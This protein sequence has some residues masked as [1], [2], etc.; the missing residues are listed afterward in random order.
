MTSTF[1]PLDPQTVA[2][3]RE[4]VAP[5]SVIE[6]RD[7]REPFGRD[8]TAEA[9]AMPE[10][11]VEATSAGQISALL[12]LANEFRFPVTPRGL[13]TGL[14]GGAVPI[15]GG[16][17]LSLAKM[18][19]ILTIDRDNFLA[20]VEPGV[21]NKD[22]KDAAR[23]AGLY[24]PPDPASYDTC[25][26]GGNAATNAGGPSCVK[27]GVTREYVLGLEAVLPTGEPIRTGVRTRKGVV[28]YDLTRLLVGSE[29]TLGV[30]TQ[31]VLK[32]IPHPPAITTLVALCPS[33]SGAMEAIRT[34]LGAGYIPCVVEFLDRHC[35]DLVGDLLPF[36]GVQDTGAFLLI[37]TD[38]TPEI[39]AR[40]IEAIGEICLGSGADQ[41]LLAPDAQR[42]ERMWDVRKA[43][44]LRIEERYPVDVHEDIVVPI[45]CI[46]DFV[47][48]LPPLED[49]YGMQ[50]FTFG[51]AGDGNLHL[52]I[53]ADAREARERID[54]GIEEI[55]K[56]VLDMGGT[57]SGEHGIGMMKSRYLPLELS[58]ESMRLQR[59]IKEL[60][61]PQGILNPGKIFSPPS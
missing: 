30:I 56:L 15:H 39:I 54:R 10:L 52:S 2:R 29:G 51:H 32:L 3:I 33:L 1:R 19:R 50:I 5:A 12:K 61:D 4:A 44:S 25:S 55:L 18:N 60:F 8:G 58:P 36:E 35:L 42:R 20:V 53:T 45:R 11:V 59:R 26:I 57:I 9:F 27:Y 48:R 14:A 13:G 6:D 31:L 47:R 43:V 22:L 38:G 21:L 7:K 23:E 40:E 28:G 34:V 17:L 49:A 24:Y 16:V 46:A 37:E 41:V